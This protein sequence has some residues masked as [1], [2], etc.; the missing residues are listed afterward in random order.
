MHAH[1]IELHQALSSYY[2]KKIYC[3]SLTIKWFENFLINSFM[4]FIDICD[5]GGIDNR[6]DAS[7]V[8]QTGMLA[9]TGDTMGRRYSLRWRQI[10]HLT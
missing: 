10:D 6:Y 4:D 8:C 9:M 5:C 1:A 2:L 7:L 3:F